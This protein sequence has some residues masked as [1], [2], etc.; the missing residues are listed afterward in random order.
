MFNGLP[1]SPT[2]RIVQNR[3]DRIERWYP[4]AERKSAKATGIVEEDESFRL[5]VQQMLEQQKVRAFHLVIFRWTY[6]FIN[7]C[8]HIWLYI[9][10][11]DLLKEKKKKKAKR[12]KKNEEH[13]AAKELRDKFAHNSIPSC[14]RQ[15]ARSRVSPTPGPS[16]SRQGNG[17]SQSTTAASLRPNPDNQCTDLVASV[18]PT[19]AGISNSTPKLP[20]GP[21]GRIAA[22]LCSP[23]DDGSMSAIVGICE[24]TQGAS[25]TSNKL[26]ADFLAM[27]AAQIKDSNAM[28]EAELNILRETASHRASELSLAQQRLAMD[29]AQIADNREFRAKELDLATK[30][31]ENV[32]AMHERVI[33]GQ[34]TF[35]KNLDETK[36]ELGT[37]IDRVEVNMRRF[38]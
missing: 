34:T 9:Y 35:A 31:Q 6:S 38:A 10:T 24:K 22:A 17:P 2:S 25:E 21:L 28:K 13:S 1:V 3:L 32:S 36:A 19:D 8:L 23:S 33:E 12:G 29:Q 5:L 30:T 15:Q 16:T 11:Q 4:K 37:K 7:F 20:R 14:Q 26:T 18:E 27:K